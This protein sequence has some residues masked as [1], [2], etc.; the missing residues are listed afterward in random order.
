MLAKITK[1]EGSSAKAEAYPHIVHTE[2]KSQAPQGHF[3]FVEHP[4]PPVAGLGSVPLLRTDSPVD[5]K[6]LPSVATLFGHK[7]DFG[8]VPIAKGH[9]S[10]LR[11]GMSL[12]PMLEV[13]PSL[14]KTYRFR[15]SSALSGVGIG[16]GGILGALGGITTVVNSKVTAWASSFKINH[17]HIWLPAV[18]GLD[19]VF[20]DWAPAGSAGFVKD[21]AKIFTVPDGITVTNVLEFRPP[22]KTLASYWNNATVSLGTLL[23]GITAPAGT[24]V[25]LNVSYTL[26][27]VT[28]PIQ[29]TVTAAVLGSVY[30]LALDG[31]GSNKLVPL[32]VPTTA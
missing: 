1:F 31:A 24:I 11:K 19:N 25:D 23:A 28:A 22:A 30:Y 17:F 3:V 13:V 7:R 5:E 6:A 32:G 18:A 15:A 10:K 29:Q 2:T 12:P 20:I 14:T 21:E 9:G 16:V 27:N 4:L 8:A 26:S